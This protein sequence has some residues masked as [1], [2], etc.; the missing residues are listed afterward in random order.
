[1][2]VAHWTTKI[3]YN[4]NKNIYKIKRVSLAAQQLSKTVLLQNQEDLKNYTRKNY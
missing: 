4:Y 2:G 3:N 1:M